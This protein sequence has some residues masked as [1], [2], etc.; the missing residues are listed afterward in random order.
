MY[1]LSSYKP[2]LQ[3]RNFSFTLSDHVQYSQEKT[4]YPNQ[5][6]AADAT[7]AAAAQ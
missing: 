5:C 7:I 4:H 6:V 1:I 2:I 3:T